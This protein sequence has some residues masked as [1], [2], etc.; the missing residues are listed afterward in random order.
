MRKVK[1]FVMVLFASV[2]LLLISNISNAAA[3]TD[4]VATKIIENTDGSVDFKLTNINVTEEHQYT[5]GASKTT[6][7]KDIT[8]WY[9]LS[10]Y[11]TSKKTAVVNFNVG[12]SSIKKL[13][14]TTDT[15]WI[16]IKDNE[17]NYIVEGLKVDLKLPVLK[18]FYLTEDKTTTS[19]RSFSILPREIYNIRSYYYKFEKI[20]NENIISAYQ[21]AIAKNLDLSTIPSLATLSDAPETGWKAIE[22]N[23]GTSGQY[24]NPKPT[25]QGLYYIWLKAVDSDSK[26]VIGYN[27]YYADAQG[28]LVKS[29][30]VT[31]P[32]SGTYKTSQTVKIRVYFDETITGTSVP[33][34]KIKF[35]DSAER[36][37]TNGTISGRYI[38]Y[39][40][41]IQ[42]SD[43]GQL[44]TVSL[45]GGTIK[46][47]SGNDA[48]L[49]CPIISGNTIKANVDGTTTNHTDNQDKTNNGSN[50]GNTTNGGSNNGDSSNS[51]STTN[52]TT[53]NGSSNN[54]ATTNGGTTNNETSKENDKTIATGKLPQTGVG[55]GLS[56]LLFATI[57]ASIVFYVKNRKY[58]GI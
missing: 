50:N 1:Y 19:F 16:F 49:S 51:G 52:G 47:A 26:V 46:D 24:I 27:L 55:I 56:T 57:G 35:G 5:W 20:T 25:E 33:T 2:L 12:E 32:A 39:S 4:V 31:S 11:N 48:K 14:K 6:E 7:A 17:D 30:E 40:Y 36:S 21:D 15:A 34:L 58:K 13:L 29:I 10:T 44:A 22:G 41:N 37:V 53:N 38:E 28:P 43:K 23:Y 18:A 54:D 45:S 8:N 9:T 42:D 3:G